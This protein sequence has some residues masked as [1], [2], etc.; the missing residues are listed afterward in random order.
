MN[1][2]GHCGKM[3]QKLSNLIGIISYKIK[4]NIYSSDF[5]DL[6]FNFREKIFEYNTSETLPILV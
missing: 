5:L 3:A 4:N 1:F 6:K 2:K